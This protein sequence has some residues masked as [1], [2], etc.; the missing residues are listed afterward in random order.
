MKSLDNHLACRRGIVKESLPNYGGQAL[1]EG[2]MMRG[3]NICAIAAR[4][5]DGSILIERQRLGQIYRSWLARIP[6]FRGL[7]ILGDALILGMRALTFSVNVQ[8][9]EDEKIEGAPM[10]ITLLLSLTAGIALF[11]M[12]PVGIAYLFEIVFGIKGLGIS[13]VEGIVRLLLLIGYIWGIGFMPDI[14]RVYGY[15]G[16]EHKTINAFEAGMP[17]EVDAVKNSS[18]SHARC[19]TSFTL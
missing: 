10:V 8:A 15:H 18:T 7:L 3:Q 2:V 13:I 16:A 14:R 17:L 11:F 19:G 5:P 9:E 6:F 4:A 1:V 12:L